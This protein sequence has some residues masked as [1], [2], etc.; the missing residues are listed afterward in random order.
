MPLE[1][2]PLR[3]GALA[4]IDLSRGSTTVLSAELPEV[5]I[6]VACHQHSKIVPVDL[7]KGRMGIELPLRIPSTNSLDSGTQ[8]RDVLSEV[9]RVLRRNQLGG[10][11]RAL[12]PRQYM[13]DQ[14][15]QRRIA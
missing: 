12:G 10:C 4:L 8:L 11:R 14:I 9:P 6:Q 3:D 1:S 15:P 13:D 5:M 2:P 7:A